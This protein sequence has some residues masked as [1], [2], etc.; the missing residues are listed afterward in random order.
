MKKQKVRQPSACLQ[1]DL[2]SMRQFGEFAM[3]SVGG[4]KVLVP[5]GRR[6]AV[7]DLPCDE[8]GRTLGE[9]ARSAPPNG[10]GRPNIF[11]KR[12][13][14]SGRQYAT[15]A[16]CSL[17]D[18]TARSQDHLPGRSATARELR[19]ADS[20]ALPGRLKGRRKRGRAE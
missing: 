17:C 5:G 14:K 10:Q 8:C 13:R 9:A 1:D 18:P 7:D 20:S 2:D 3:H 4:Q 16:L 6:V 19:R 11:V 15:G 12:G